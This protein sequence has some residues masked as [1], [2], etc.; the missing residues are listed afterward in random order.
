MAENLNSLKYLLTFV[1]FFSCNPNQQSTHRNMLTEFLMS[2]ELSEY[3]SGSTISFY[4]EHFYLMGDDASDLVVLNT[5]L[6]I[7][8]QIPLFTNTNPRIAKAEKADIE[9]SEW[10]INEG[11]AKLWLFSSGSLSPQRDSAFCFDPETRTIERLNLESF[12]RQL[13]K[14]G[15]AELN[16]EA[17]ASVKDLLLFGSRGNDSNRQ[18]Y[19]VQ[20]LANHFPDTSAFR[21]IQLRLPAGAGISG[22][23]YL[24]AD[25]IL[26][27]T[28]SIEHTDS[29]YDDGEIGESSLGFIYSISEKLGNQSVTPEDWIKLSKLHPDFAGQKIESVTTQDAENGE[30]FVTLVSDDDKGH[31]RLFRLKLKSNND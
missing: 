8:Q 12:Y 29:A 2:Q 30:N 4:D 22:M 15:I 11:K 3:P 19:L 18:N 10:I 21:L 20:T 26:L 16:I 27:I 7:V 5:E 6:K 17:A 25:D 1:I 9:A 14:A 28:T 31:T 24:A 13:H 23:S